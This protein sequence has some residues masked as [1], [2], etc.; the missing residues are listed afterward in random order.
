M[1]IQQYSSN[2]KKFWSWLNSSKGKRDPI[3]LLR[4]NDVPI[5]EDSA[6]ADIFN[7]YFHSVF[8]KEDISNLPELCKSLN[9]VPPLISS[10][11]FSPTVVCDYLCAID[12]SKA[13]GPDLI[14]GFLLRFCAESIPVPLSYLYTKSMETGTLPRDWVTANIVPVYKK[15]DKCDASNYRPI[16]LTSIVVKIM[17]RIIHS[18]LTSCLEAHGL[19][20]NH[21]YGFRRHRSTTHLLLEATYDW[22]HT[23]ELR[24]SCHCLF[25]DFSKAF[26]T[27]PHSRLLLKLESLGIAGDL[28][29]WVRAFLTA[30][31]Q[32]VVVNGSHS[33]WLPVISGVPQ[34]SILG[35]LLF[36]LYVNDI[37]S[38]ISHSYLKMFA[39]DLT[40]YRNIAS[41]SD[42]EL[43]Q[44]D[45]RRIY[46]WTLTWLLRLNLLKCEALN[47][48]NKAVLYILITILDL[49]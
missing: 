21:Q 48:T 16:S 10:V 42:C 41:V 11:E 13:C 39:D 34:G 28:L 47:I 32:R 37:K 26:D 20:L 19:I 6:K 2:P 30:R 4:H 9:F 36:I 12:D 23:L 33:S 14:T 31:A 45:L 22:A 44:W 49:I 24:Q 18:Q 1:T 5:L 43:L 8:T 38:V 25:L 17:E 46:E 27:V 15:G 40:L 29:N 7:Q 3:P 35:P